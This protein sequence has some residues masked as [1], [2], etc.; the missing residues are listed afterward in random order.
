MEFDRDAQEQTSSTAGVK[1]L[2]AR[3][4]QQNREVRRRRE[5]VVQFPNCRVGRGIT[6]LNQTD[7][8]DAWQAAGPVSAARPGKITAGPTPVQNGK[9]NTPFEHILRFARL[10]LS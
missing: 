9:V 7:A 2:R 4:E 6:G 3:L 1:A 8:H 10:I 5:I